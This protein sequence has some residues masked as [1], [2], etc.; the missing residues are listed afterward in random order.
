MCG[1]W[2]RGVVRLGVGGG[3]RVCSLTLC[4]AGERVRSVWGEQYHSLSGVRGVVVSRVHSLQH[5]VYV[6]GASAPGS[7][8]S[9]SQAPVW[10]R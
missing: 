5:A 10:G 2:V 9:V 3:R 4:G 7:G 6:P 8:A 1:V